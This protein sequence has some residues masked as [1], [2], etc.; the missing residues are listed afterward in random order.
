M[1]VC[2]NNPNDKE[3]YTTADE[4]HDWKVDGEGNFI[5]D[6]GCSEV[7]HSPDTNNV[8]TCAICEAYAIDKEAE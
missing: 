1:K 5:E 4:V 8:W 6:L 2:P 3:F 7:A